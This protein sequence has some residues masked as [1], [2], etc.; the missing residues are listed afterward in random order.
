[1]TC[2]GRRTTSGWARECVG[3]PA[4]KQHGRR[5][6]AFPWDGNAKKGQGSSNG[7]A[8]PVADGTYYMKFTLIK[9][10]GTKEQAETWTS[11][12]F[13]IDRP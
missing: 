12:N 7:N 9:A 10:L 8:G 11:P 4:A 2:T 13:V 6:F 5:F 1:M 3:L